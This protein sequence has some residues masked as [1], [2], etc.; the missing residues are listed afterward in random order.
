MIVPILERPDAEAAPSA[1]RSRSPTGP[2]AA[3]RTRRPRRCSTRRLATRSPTRRGRCSCSAC[4]QALPDTRYV[5][6]T[7]ALPMLRA[8]KDARRDRAPRRRGRGRRRELRG[9]SPRCASPGRTENEIAADLAG[10]LSTTATRRWTSP[11]SAPGPNGANPHHEMASARS[12]RATWSCSTSA[13]SRTATAPTP[14]ARSTSASP[15]TRSARSTRS[16]AAPSRP[17]SRPCARASR[18][19]RSTAPRA[20]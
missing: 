13:A 15:P 14:R 11:S 2:T 17:A 1:G 12:R 19:R 6:M 10:L 16:C 7:S 4:R 18:A 5:S 3:I 8:I 9:A 20:R